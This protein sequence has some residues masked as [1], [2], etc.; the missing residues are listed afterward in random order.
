MDIN[1][2]WTHFGDGIMLN[3][4]KEM[5]RTLPKNIKVDF[6]GNIKNSDLLDIYKNDQFDLFLNVSLSEGIPVSIM[7]AL[8]FGIPCIATDVGGTREIVTDGYNGWLLKEDFKEEQLVRIIKKYCE[9]NIE[10][11]MKLRECAYKSWKDKYNAE[12]NYT[13]FVEN[14]L[15][16]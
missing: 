5:S 9:L 11:I 7:E 12:K 8:S 4:I 2:K 3:Q 14:L 6:R 15:K 10:Q 1:I 16:I 13:L